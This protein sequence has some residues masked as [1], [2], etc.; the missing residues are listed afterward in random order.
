MICVGEIRDSETAEMAM[1]AAQTGH[2]VL[3]TLHASS[4][5]GAL[6][7]LMDLGVKPLLISSALSVVISQR[8]I[9]KLCESC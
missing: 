4:N 6:V 1:Q 2:L 7:R 9:R 8:L 3:A 5:M